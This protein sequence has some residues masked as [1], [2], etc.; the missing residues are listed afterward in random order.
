MAISDTARYSGNG[1][2]SLG[3]EKNGGEAK[4]VFMSQNALSQSLV[5]SNPSFFFR[6]LKKGWHLSVAFDTNVVK[7]V[8]LPAKL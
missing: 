8:I 4:Y 6:A 7:A 1:S 3:L 2:P 5:Y